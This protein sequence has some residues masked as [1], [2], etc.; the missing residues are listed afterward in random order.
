MV[1]R[2]I[3]IPIEVHY[4]EL[5]ELISSDAEEDLKELL[6]GIYDEE[7]LKKIKIKQEDIWDYID[8]EMS[9][10]AEDEYYKE[11]IASKFK[12]YKKLK[13]TKILSIDYNGDDEY[14]LTLAVLEKDVQKFVELY[15]KFYKTDKTL[16][17][18]FNEIQ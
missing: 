16:E 12:P 11:I 15:N 18:I 9:N 13:D 1:K 4:P 10:Y 2:Y 7:E 8:I 6:A 5:Y 17:D 14:V 3:T